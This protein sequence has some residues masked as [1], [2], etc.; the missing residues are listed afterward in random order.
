MNCFENN[1]EQKLKMTQFCIYS[2][3]FIIH[4]FLVLNRF[5]LVSVLGPGAMNK[6]TVSILGKQDLVL[7]EMKDTKLFYQIKYLRQS[8]MESHVM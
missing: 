7:V 3:S 5:L 6:S 4:R 8:L 1:C 2:G